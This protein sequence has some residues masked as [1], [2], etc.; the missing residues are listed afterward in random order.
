MITRRRSQYS[1]RV[2][3]KQITFK[4]FIEYLGVWVDDKLHFGDYIAKV[5]KK[6]RKIA[7]VLARILPNIGGVSMEKRRLYCAV[8]NR[9]MMYAAQVWAEATA[10]VNYSRNF[11]ATHRACAMRAIN[12]YCTV[13]TEAVL[14]LAR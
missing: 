1:P 7:M 5:T 3:I 13:S 12:A 10:T 9:V 8:V 2:T 14:M 4:R 6:A 11:I